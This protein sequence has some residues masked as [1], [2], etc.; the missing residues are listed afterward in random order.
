MTWLFGVAVAL[1]VLPIV[2]GF[3]MPVRYEGMTTVEYDCS[4]QQVWDALQDAE[5]HPMTGKVMKSVE[6]LPPDEGGPAWKEDMGHGEVVTVRTTVF[7]PPR[8]CRGR[9]YLGRQDER[10]R[11]DTRIR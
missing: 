2:I 6:T 3:L 1:L 5:A 9:P 7:E 4:V 11:D 10:T 8:Q